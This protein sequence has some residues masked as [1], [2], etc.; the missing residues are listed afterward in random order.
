MS[1]K[2][3]S[4]NEVTQQTPTNNG[5]HTG[6]SRRRFI[7]GAAAPVVLSVISKPVMATGRVCTI[8][9]F[10]SV[11]P[12]GVARHTT[13]GCGGLS[14]GAWRNPYS[15]N[16]DGGYQ[17]WAAV[18]VVPPKPSESMSGVNSSNI[19]Y[20]RDQ[21]F[22]YFGL[23]SRPKTYKPETMFGDIFS[24]GS[25]LNMSLYDILNGDGSK[26]AKFA[27]T[28]FLNASYF[29]WGVT[30]LNK[31]HPLDVVALYDALPGAYVRTTSGS[32]VVR[33]GDGELKNFFENLQH[34]V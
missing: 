31:I 27:A 21:Y 12:S 28:A 26:L 32:Q 18:G 14:P 2:Q 20:L 24:T 17:Y 6:N 29:G 22:S 8:S 30:E 5:A 1:D 7:L 25:Y 15:G 34:Y 13:S 3:S 10:T 19:N 9:G 23:S 16:S 33:P 4:Q 11:N